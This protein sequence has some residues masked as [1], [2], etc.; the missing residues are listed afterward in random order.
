MKSGTACINK[1]V[2]ISN[3]PFAALLLISY[4]APIV[5]PQQFWPLAFLGLIYPFLLAINLVYFFY[6]LVQLRTYTLVSGMVILLGWGIFL[7]NF[8]FRFKTTS[9][10]ESRPANSLRVMTF[11]VHGFVDINQ[12]DSFSYKKILNLIRV[13]NPDII[14]FQEF[15]SRN[16][17]FRFFDS[18]KNALGSGQYYF[19]PFIKSLDYKGL[20]ID[21]TGL[22]IF[23]KTPIIKHDIFRLSDGETDNQ[24]VS[25]DVKSRLGI[26]R[27]YSFH[28]QSIMLR[29][30][31]LKFMRKNSYFDKH[32]AHETFK[33]I[34]TAFIS[35]AQQV[36][37]I[38]AKLKECPYSYVL[39]GDFND[40]P[41][42]YVFHQM[43]DGLTNAFEKKGSG[44]GVTYNTGIPIFQIDFILAHPKYDIINY[45]IIKQKVSDH[46][47]IYADLTLK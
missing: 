47:A 24:G 46:Y 21:S 36:L 25:I 5:G 38:K 33:K 8:G 10:L 45:Q 2:F 37:L 17:K 13:Q 43:A 35:R 23:S 26:L 12:P 39:A 4:L 3:M 44:W 28:L 34:K 40:T 29:R 41:N 6:W 18:L 1:V 31:D 16:A 32:S 19:E 42:S 20:A 14:A 30:K 27:I 7:N 9:N 15:T 11:N 22:A